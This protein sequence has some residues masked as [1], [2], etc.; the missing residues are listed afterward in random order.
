MKVAILLLALFALSACSKDPA[1]VVKC[2]LKDENIF[3]DI[4]KL[5]DV[6]AKKEYGKIFQVILE[7]YPDIINVIKKCFQEFSEE[8]GW[9]RV[10][11]ILIQLFGPIAKEWAKKGLAYL[12]KMCKKKWGNPMCELIPH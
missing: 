1:E 2:V 12:Y 9:E 3:K 8:D 11:L 5:V 7:I 6:I 10:L 4:A